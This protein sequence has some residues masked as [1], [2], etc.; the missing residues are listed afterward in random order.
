MKTLVIAALASSFSLAAFANCTIYVPEVKRVNSQGMQTKEMK[1][2]MKA[3]SEEVERH[4]ILLSEL[5]KK[6][7]SVVTDER[8]AELKAHIS[9]DHG[10]SIFDTW[11]GQY[12]NAPRSA[13]TTLTISGENY[14][15]V[16]SGGLSVG[17]F[18]RLVKKI[19]NCVE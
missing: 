15:K 7:F 8:Q 18:K 3:K 9:L 16:E 19:P 1:E 4:G 5:D 11:F 2:K 14:F 6:G 12:S 17:S 10:L 13:S